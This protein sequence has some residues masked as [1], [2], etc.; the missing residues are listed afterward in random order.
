M[1]LV[2][3]HPRPGDGRP[4]RGGPRGRGRLPPPWARRRPASPP[5]GPAPRPH[6]GRQP[7][8][9]RG[10][11][12]GR[13]GAGGDWLAAPPGREYLT[14]VGRPSAPGGAGGPETTAM[15]E[16][17][18]TAPAE[19][20]HESEPEIDLRAY[21]EVLRKR[22]WSILAVFALFVAATAV[23]T[24]RQPRIYK[25]TTSVVIDPRAPNVLKG[26]SD[27]VEIGAGTYW[28]TQEFYNTEY[29]VIQSLE[30]ARRVVER[31]GLDRDPDFIGP[32]KEGEEPPDAAAILQSMISVEPVR[33]SRMVEIG[34]SDTDPERAALLST[35]VAEVYRDRNL[36]RRIEGSGSAVEWLTE[37]LHTLKPKLEASEMRLFEFRKEND[38]LSA[39]LEDRQNIV[40][41]RL[42]ALNAQLTDLEAKKATLGAK[43]DQIRALQKE[44]KADR[45]ALE[46][47]AEVTQSELIRRLKENLFQRLQEYAALKE[48]YLEKHPK[49]VQ[50]EEALKSARATLDAEV[51]KIV[52]SIENEYRQVVDAE[53]RV[54][55]LVEETK[56]EAFELNK[57]EI[58]YSRLVREKEENERVYQLV[59]SR[60]K[61]ASLAG[62]QQ[63]NNVRIID[64]A[65]DKPQGATLVSPRYVF[66]LSVAGFL[67]LL[68][69]VGLAFL[70]EYLDNT[71]KSQEDVEQRLGLPFLGIIPLVPRDGEGSPDLHILH[72]PRGQVAEACR[73]I[74]TNL[75]FMSPD[76]PL[77]RIV[78]TSAGPREG[79]TTTVIDLGIVMA[80]SGAKVLLVDTDMRRPRLHKALGVPGGAGLSNLILGEVEI[81]E[82]IRHTDVEGMSLLPCGPIPPNPAELLHAHR[83]ETLLEELS[84][85]YDRILLDSPP[86]G[87]VADAKILGVRADGALLVARAGQTTREMLGHA[88]GSLL[89]VNAHI[90]GVVLNQVDLSKKSYGYYYQ[91]YRGYGEYYGKPDE[92]QA[93]GGA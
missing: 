87:A 30:I 28:H 56:A 57:K 34:V 33:D 43:V 90:L 25:A 73:S 72:H 3:M 2:G 12:R 88:A 71:V 77:K 7:A 78:V 31:L 84:K 47:L 66:N 83:F 85:R 27:V 1:R 11:R 5:H 53:R 61:E 36:E 63:A 54:R 41:Q 26:V 10:S 82:V 4:P 40:S 38:M 22:I 89:D 35:T 19:A 55:R 50:A 20:T 42:L 60:I 74:R 52:A 32:V 16:P 75:L 39:S 37:Q 68:F 44:A 48:K 93:E 65:V 79:K 86:L 51:D 23:W 29:K 18:P 9:P 69:G 8:A 64:R 45:S 58:E 14:R 6:P 15:T 76:A 17:L 24:L 49:L 46:A 67:G 62:Q 81:D 59:L 80:Q 92:A 91:Y 21:Y 13:R 70:R